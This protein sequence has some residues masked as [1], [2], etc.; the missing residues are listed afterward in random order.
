M[1]KELQAADYENL[2]KLDNRNEIKSSV[3]ELESR[4]WLYQNK[5]II[6][7]NIDKLKRIAKFKDAIALTNTQSL[8]IKKSSLSDLLITEE[9]IKRF[10]KELKDL[11]GVRINV[12]LINSTFA[13]SKWG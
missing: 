10:Q 13:E 5:T 7:E 9:Y 1:A 4:K 12:D 6:T 2:S 8:S 3:L 11:G